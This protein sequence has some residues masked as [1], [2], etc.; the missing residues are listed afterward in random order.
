MISEWKRKATILKKRP[1]KYRRWL[2]EAR[3]N[4]NQMKRLV[5][6]FKQ[7]KRF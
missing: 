3:T 4:L 7:L 2:G 5:I 1:Q 6:F